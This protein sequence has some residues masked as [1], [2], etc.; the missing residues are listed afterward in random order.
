VIFA[1]RDGII[2]LWNAQAQ[3][4][5]GHAAAEA[6]GKSLDLIIPEHL[7]AAHW[8]GYEQ[9]LATGRTRLEG[10]AMLTRAVHKDGRKVYVELA[11]NIVRGASGDIL[12]AVATGRIA[13]RP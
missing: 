11:F 3:A 2:R 7:R 4:F 13:S 5:F 8:R 12:G 6:I 10:K 9:A 1:D